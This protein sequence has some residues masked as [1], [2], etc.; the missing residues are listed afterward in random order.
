MV[1]WGGAAL[2]VVSAAGLGIYLATAG[3]DGADKLGS[4]IGAFVG[5]AGLVL[6]LY[7]TR[8]GRP[9]RSASGESDSGDHPNVEMVVNS[10]GIGQTIQ[11]EQIGSVT[12]GSPRPSSAHRDPPAAG[13]A[14]GGDPE[15]PR[16][17]L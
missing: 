17:P 2:A 1:T 9:G 5:L 13:P 4:V 8:A 14:P 15:E 11:A 16:T 12:L 10:G 3:L 6:A 7:G